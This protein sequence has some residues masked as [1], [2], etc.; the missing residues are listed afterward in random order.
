MGGSRRSASAGLIGGMAIATV[1]ALSLTALAGED[2][3]PVAAGVAA[4]GATMTALDGLLP[5][6]PLPASPTAASEAPESAAVPVALVVQA[7]TSV[8]TGDVLALVRQ[9]FPADQVGNAMAVARCESGHANAIG[10]TNRNGTTDWGVF[11]LN[12]GGTLQGALRR[13]GAG[14]TSLAEAQQLALDAETNVRAARTIYDNRG[15]APWVCAYKTGIV[16]SLYSN[17][18]GPM[19]GRYDERGR[20]A[21]PFTV[22]D[23]PTEEPTP[24]ADATPAAATPAAPTPP[25]KPSPGTTPAPTPTPTPSPTPTPV[26]TPTPTP[27]PEPTEPPA[28]TAPAEP[29]DQP[30]E[31][32]AEESDPPT[33]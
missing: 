9:Y 25:P 31:G 11:Q 8:G 6:P 1:A 13:I 22:A 29:T 4:T 28:T 10:A 20:S 21:T 19:A 15:W 27:T 14:F 17:T 3:R 24:T 23:R 26:P 30:V 33:E 12:D 7:T 18:P 16:A 32:S 5:V 2:A